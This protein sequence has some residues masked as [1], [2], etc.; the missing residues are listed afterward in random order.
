ML[1]LLCEIVY[2]AQDYNPGQN[3][4]HIPPM[5]VNAQFRSKFVSW[6]LDCRTNIEPGG[7]GW[8]KKSF[9]DRL[10]VIRCVWLM[11]F[12]KM[13]KIKACVNT[14]CTGLQVRKRLYQTAA[15][16]S[17]QLSSTYP[18]NVPNASK[19]IPS[20]VNETQDH[21]WLLFGEEL[22]VC[23]FVGLRC[24]T[25]REPSR[26]P[27]TEQNPHRLTFTRTFF[28]AGI[29]F[30]RMWTEN[31][32]HFFASWFR[33][34]GV[35][36]PRSRYR[37]IFRAHSRLQ[38]FPSKNSVLADWIHQYARFEQLWTLRH[39]CLVHKIIRRSST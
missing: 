24:S 18:P 29:S 35:V 19:S 5:L 9:W 26:H 23:V 4:W 7:G 17:L 28:L 33:S 38:Y 16:H 39:D 14:F 6:P 22:Q 15:S 27:E 21:L 13:D 36:M 31:Q 12:R 1:K 11:I 2:G 10:E 20:D 25:E 3:C 34:D 37:W 30:R 32:R 8:E